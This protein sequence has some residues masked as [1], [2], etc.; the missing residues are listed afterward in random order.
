MHRHFYFRCVTINRI[1]WPSAPVLAVHPKYSVSKENFSVLLRRYII[2]AP[3]L[4]L[5]ALCL[6]P[7][8]TVALGFQEGGKTQQ[9][10]KKEDKSKETEQP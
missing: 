8:S 7:S 10:E 3:A 1:E 2:F 9:A 5:L 4:I 6:P